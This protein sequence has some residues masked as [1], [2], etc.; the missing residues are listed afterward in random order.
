MREKMP[1][2]F[3]LNQQQM[4]DTLLYTLPQW[5]IFAAVFVAVYGWIEKKKAFRIIG[6]AI[7]ILLGIYSLIIISG[8]Y[9]A[10]GE[11]LTPGEIAD[12]ELDGETNEEIP[13]QAKLMPAYLSFIVSAII[14]IPTIFL[15]IKNN[16]R[17]QWFILSAGLV[18]LFGF[19]VIVGVLQYL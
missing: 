12:I 2:L 8:G 1:T 16:K 14:A 7:F 11:F 9:L 10:G 15:D 4:N 13:F 3:P 6:A 5:F 17:Y 19:F 18:A